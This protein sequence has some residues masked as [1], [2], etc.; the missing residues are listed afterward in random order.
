MD[1]D[2]VLACL[3]KFVLP[4]VF[5]LVFF[6]YIIRRATN[7][8]KSTYDQYLKKAEAMNDATLK[9]SLDNQTEMIAIL[10][11]IRDSLKK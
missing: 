8:N 9:K 11:E 6:E 10:K 1:W 3:F 5:I 2:Y 7:R 4:C